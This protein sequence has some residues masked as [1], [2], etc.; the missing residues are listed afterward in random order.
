MENDYRCII[1]GFITI[2]LAYLFT[3]KKRKVNNH[4]IIQN[5]AEIMQGKTA[6]ITGSSRGIGLQTALGLARMGAYVIIVSHNQE[7]YEKARD[8][9]VAIAGKHSVNYYLADLSSQEEIRKL[10]SNIK[11][12]YRHLDVLINNVGGWFRRFQ[13]SSDKIEMTLA[14]N[15]LSYF[16]LTGLLLDLIKDNA[17]SRIINVSSNAHRTINGIQFKDIEFKENYKAFQIYAQSK[18]A[19]LMFTNELSKRLKGTNVTE[20]ALH[21]G[22]VNSKL[23]QDFGILT[24]F[25]KLFA[26]IFGKSSEE[27]AETS[28]YLASSSEVSDVSGKYFVDNKPERS[29]EAS[30]N[31]EA[32]KHLWE[33]SEDMTNFTFSV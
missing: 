12:D 30:Y 3:I 22:F 2:S 21:P 33:L 4:L 5:Q 11:K 27:G 14:L 6:L 10:A 31:Q 19:N 7:H 28:I 17:P 8:Q 16:L 13:T 15:H 25:I 32:W 20:N 1:D 9:I 18:L 23:Y 29:S 24:P 26:L